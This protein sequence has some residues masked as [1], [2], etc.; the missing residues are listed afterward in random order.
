MTLDADAIPNPDRSS[1]VDW[2]DVQEPNST[3]IVNIVNNSNFHSVSHHHQQQQQQ[4]QR[5]RIW[6]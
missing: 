2:N 1:D 3:R 5:R 6:I 4:Q